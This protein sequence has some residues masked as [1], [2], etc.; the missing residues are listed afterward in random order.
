MSIKLNS[1]LLTLVLLAVFAMSGCSDS[2]SQGTTDAPPVAV[3]ESVAKALGELWEGLNANNQEPYNSLKEKTFELTL[4]VIS[5]AIQ[6]Q[7]K[8]GNSGG[9]IAVE[10][11]TILES[12][13]LAGPQKI[14][15]M[16]TPEEL[17]AVKYDTGA[18]VV[19]GKV[20]ATVAGSLN[21]KSLVFGLAQEPS[22]INLTKD[23]AWP[24]PAAVWDARMRSQLQKILMAFVAHD[25]YTNGKEQVDSLDALSEYGYSKD[26]E[27]EIEYMPTKTSTGKNGFIATAFSPDGKYKMV[28]TLNPDNGEYNL[29]AEPIE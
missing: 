20:K 14:F 8:A 21:K 13:S 10:A 9:K 19:W 17:A 28:G 15:L 6:L 22:T 26:S 4:A 11:F 25:S 1:F 5:P 12:V 29:K 24:I 3:E 7:S 23:E 2:G 18:P 27:F 16:L